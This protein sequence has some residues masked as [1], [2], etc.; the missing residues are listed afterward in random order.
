MTQE[1]WVIPTECSSASTGQEI[2]NANISR[3]FRSTEQAGGRF[4]V[5]VMLEY[6]NFSMS[7]LNPYKHKTSFLNFRDQKGKFP[8]RLMLRGAFAFFATWPLVL[9]NYLHNQRLEN[10][11]NNRYSNSVPQKKR[12][13]DPDFLP[14]ATVGVRGK[15]DMI[16]IWPNPGFADFV[17]VDFTSTWCSQTT[18]GRCRHLECHDVPRQRFCKSIKPWGFIIQTMFYVEG[19]KWIILKCMQT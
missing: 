14:N 6:Q 18:D 2:G 19:T 13:W 17:H 3:K 15:L 8:K 1:F 4:Y 11:L 7:M 12:R 16:L 10:A 5:K 9:E